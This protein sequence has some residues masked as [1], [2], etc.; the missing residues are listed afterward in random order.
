MV[1]Q[2]ENKN[3]SNHPTSRLLLRLLD[4]GCQIRLQDET[5]KGCHTGYAER[6][7]LAKES[8]QYLCMQLAYW[9]GRHPCGSANPSQR[10]MERIRRSIAADVR[11]QLTG[12]L[13]SMAADN[14]FLFDEKGRPVCA[15][16]N[17]AAGLDF[18]AE[19]KKQHI[20]LQ[21]L[22]R[23]ECAA[24]ARFTAFGR[25]SRLLSCRYRLKAA[26]IFYL[27]LEQLP[28]CRRRFGRM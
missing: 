18:V 15:V 12:R 3:I 4:E 2:P 26:I 13:L 6:I 25:L 7:R 17:L 22:N 23:F 5:C 24:P 19:A 16:P 1:R 14:P 10:E 20:R 11:Q 27:L 21:C 28:F 8:A 9:D